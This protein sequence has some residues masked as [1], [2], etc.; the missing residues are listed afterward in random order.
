MNYFALRCAIRWCIVFLCVSLLATRTDVM[1]Q[2]SYT[3]SWSV[4]G[5]IVNTSQISYGDALGDNLL[6]LEGEVCAGKSF[7]GWTEIEDYMH[8]NIAPECLNRM[9]I[10]TSDVTY[11]AVFAEKIEGRYWIKTDINDI[12]STDDVWI[13][14]EV[15][16][17]DKNYYYYA[18]R[19]DNQTTQKQPSSQVQVHNNILEMTDALLILLSKHTWNIIKFDDSFKI[20]LKE[21]P[22]LYLYCT[23]TEVCVN[24][25]ADNDNFTIKDGYLYNKDKKKYLYVKN[26][27][28]SMYW[29]C[30]NNKNHRVAL[31]KKC[32]YIFQNFTTTCNLYA[33]LDIQIVEWKKDAIVVMYNGDPNGKVDISVDQET[34]IEDVELLS[35]IK[36]VA[37]YEITIP[38]L[39][40]KPMKQLEVVIDNAIKV[41]DIPIIVYSENQDVPNAESVDMVILK[42]GVC[43]LREGVNYSLRNVDIYGGGKL[44][45]ETNSVLNVSSLKMRI[46]SV[47][48]GVYVS[49]YPQ[50]LL[51]GSVGELTDFYVDYLTT[52]DR[53][54]ALSLPYEVN[55]KDIHYPVDIYGDNVAVDNRGSFQLQYYH[56]ASR[57]ETGKGWK[58]L[59]EPSEGA[60]LQPYQGYTFWGAPKKVSVNGADKKRQLFG[61]HR[62]PI[63]VSGAD[64]SAH[65]VSP[66]TISVTAYGDDDS[67]NN[68]R[69]WNFVGNPYLSQYIGL[70]D[71]NLQIGMLE[72]EMQDGRWNGEYNHVGELRYVTLTE[73]GQTY[74]SQEVSQTILT[75]FNTYFVQVEQDGELSFVVKGDACSYTL[76]PK[77][78]EEI[79]LGVKLLHADEVD[80]MGV[81]IAE[82]FT[83]DYEINADLSKFENQGLNLYSISD[84]GKHAYMA[85][86][87]SDVDSIPL[88]YKAVEDGLYI[89]RYDNSH[90]DIVGLENVYLIDYEE[91]VITDLLTSDYV[92]D[93]ERGVY[94]Q[95]F[96]LKVELEGEDPADVVFLEESVLHVSVNSNTLEISNL[97]SN[98]EII[99][100]DLMG[101]VVLRRMAEQRNLSMILSQGY[102]IVCIRHKGDSKVLKV[103][104]T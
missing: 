20:V 93:S 19:Y 37:I 28:G 94:N 44:V 8:E 15:L 67:R 10:P 68:D 23:A 55:T 18:L 29:Y 53:Y 59:E 17:S 87:Q 41:F 81:L 66:K 47:E 96:A 16:G 82:K 39:S 35:L 103:I 49:A 42:D 25:N 7:Y 85:I 57:A 13:T 77:M 86:P 43:R 33:S 52:Y 58:V 72:K 104:I 76:L 73:D 71:S 46:G 56:G 22:S 30:D 51:H 34:L 88:G 50:L 3:I 90:Y 54:Y 70:E 69:G 75:P 101:N 4:D 92:F 2:E 97:Q 5:K 61:F 95:R 62:I 12:T 40:T 64:L 1:A 102:Y 83:S 78:S 36:D 100:Y 9:T 89:F 91:N 65:E 48:N 21:N 84:A 99:V 63:R 27:N 79:K 60:I 98:S 45:V 14:M 38:G 6:E 80:Y 31:F 26:N 74:I 32:D 24:N 11:Y